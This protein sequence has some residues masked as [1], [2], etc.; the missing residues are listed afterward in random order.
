MPTVLIAWKRLS[1]STKDMDGRKD[2][3]PYFIRIASR[4][5][6]GFSPLEEY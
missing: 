2:K 6:T 1:V 3:T 5:P 4:K